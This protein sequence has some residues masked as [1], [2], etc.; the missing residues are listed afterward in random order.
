MI[1]YL[2][3]KFIYYIKFFQ[4]TASGRRRRLG[5]H[6]TRPIQAHD[7]TGQCMTSESTSTDSVE[8][9]DVTGA[10]TNTDTVEVAK[11]A[12]TDSTAV[13]VE[14][15]ANICQEQSELQMQVHKYYLKTDYVINWIIF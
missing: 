15:A 8:I 1:T 13:E 7:K 9:V 14:G 11:A 2:K 10:V 6:R 3:N 5:Y 12:G 4:K